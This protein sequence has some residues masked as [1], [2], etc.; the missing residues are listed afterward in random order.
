MLRPLA[1]DVAVSARCFLYD[2]TEQ[3]C[4][5]GEKF[6]TH[7]AFSKERSVDYFENPLRQQTGGVDAVPEL[8][9]TTTIP[10]VYMSV[11]IKQEIHVFRHNV[12]KIYS[13]I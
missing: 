5:D 9:H 7:L 1:D 2:F 10:Y 11:W 4:L 12:M 6:I 8:C 13:G 3:K